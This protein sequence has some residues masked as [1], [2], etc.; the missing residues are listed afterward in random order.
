MVTLIVKGMKIVLWEA[1]DDMFIRLSSKERHY[2]LTEIVF[3]PDDM[4]RM[5]ISGGRFNGR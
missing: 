3:N 4:S 5:Q 2:W 1:G